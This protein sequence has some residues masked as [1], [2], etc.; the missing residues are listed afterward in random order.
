M[1]GYHFTGDRLRDGRPIPPVGEWLEHE[2]EI[3]PCVNGLHASEHPFDAMIYASGRML[4]KVEIEGD[5]ISH[6]DPV[7]K[8]VGRRRKIIASIDAEPLLRA[9]ARWCALRAIDPQAAPSVVREYLETGDDTERCTEWDAWNASWDSAWAVSWD[10][11]RAA[12]AGRAVAMNAAW[13]VE[14]AA[15]RKTFLAM[16]EAAFAADAAGGEE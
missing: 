10:A 9:F 5:L 1:I 7:N 4:H 14:M 12:A 16:V 6:G 2:G 13:A 11:G 3:V 8:W 15:Q